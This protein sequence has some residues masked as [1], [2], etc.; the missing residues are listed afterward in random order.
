MEFFELC[1]QG[2]GGAAH[3]LPGGECPATGASDFLCFYVDAGRE[4]RKG[5]VECAGGDFADHL[6]GEFVGVPLDGVVL[7]M[8]VVVDECLPAVFVAEESPAVAFGEEGFAYLVEEGVGVEAGFANAVDCEQ[9]PSAVKFGFAG[10]DFFGNITKYPASQ[11]VHQAA[12]LEDICNQ[13]CTA[14]EVVVAAVARAG[15]AAPFVAVDFGVGEGAGIYNFSHDFE[16]ARCG[17]GAANE[18]FALLS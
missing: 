8:S 5:D 14:E 3:G 9:A 17:A 15:R 16:V 6:C 1:G 10:G 18:A 2:P 7:E 12:T 13:E 4:M 11:G